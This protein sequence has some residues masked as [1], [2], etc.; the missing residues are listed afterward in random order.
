MAWRT[1]AWAFQ[2]ADRRA[3]AC[4]VRAGHR[5]DADSRRIRRFVAPP[6]RL[7]PRSSIGHARRVETPY[8]GRSTERDA[9]ATR[10]ADGCRSRHRIGRETR[11]RSASGDGPQAFRARSMRQAGVRRRAGGRTKGRCVIDRHSRRGARSAQT[12]FSAMDFVDTL[13]FGPVEGMDASPVMRPEKGASSLF[14]DD[15]ADAGPTPAQQAHPVEAETGACTGRSSAVPPP[16][17]RPGAAAPPR[18]GDMDFPAGRSASMPT[19]RSGTAGHP[20][21]TT[22]SPS[23][24]PPA[25]ANPGHRAG[26]AGRSTPATRQAATPARRMLATPSRATMLLAAM[27]AA[28]SM[29]LVVR[30]A[31]RP[32][33]APPEG[34]GALA[35]ATP[36]DEASSRAFSA[37]AAQPGIDAVTVAPGAPGAA[38]PPAPALSADGEGGQAA[39]ASSG[40]RGDQPGQRPSPTPAVQ[41]R[42]GATR[43]AVAASVAAAQS[44]ADAFLRSESPVAGKPSPGSGAP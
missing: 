24:S 19:V 44:K 3:R 16:A 31:T 37:I 22:S 25:A 6:R 1:S 10:H 13:P 18:H 20:H 15:L 2:H 40:P 41:R 39:A 14:L 42:P 35:A 23:N 43:E 5:P 33:Q 4:F 27:T 21:S 7:A 26:L 9:A 8:A 38:S 28:V 32:G 29:V 11:R 36:H 30:A 34:A 12:G 17:A